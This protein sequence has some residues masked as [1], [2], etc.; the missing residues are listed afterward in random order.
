MSADLS[1]RIYSPIAQRAADALLRS[2]GGFSVGLQMPVYAAAGDAAQIGITPQT[3]QQLPLSPAIFRRVRIPMLEGEPEKFE[4]SISASAIQALVGALQL[5][6][7]D[8]LFTQAAG[9]TVNGKLFMI[10]AVTA[11]EVFGQAYLYRLQ[12]REALAQAL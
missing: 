12:L 7:A 9:V 8:A 1:V 4:L 5:S 2:L 11:P 10:E 6:S 3:Y